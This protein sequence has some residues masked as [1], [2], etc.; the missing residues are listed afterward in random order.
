MLIDVSQCVCT[1]G[2]RGIKLLEVDFFPM[3]FLHGE[4]LYSLFLEELL[5]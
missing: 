3:T 1:F 2:H 5:A 4:E